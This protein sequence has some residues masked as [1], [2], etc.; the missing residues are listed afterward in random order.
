VDTIHALHMEHGWDPIA[1]MASDGTDMLM[2]VVVSMWLQIIRPTQPVKM[3]VGMQSAATLPVADG[4]TRL[5]FSVPDL[6]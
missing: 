3:S 4:R 2:A 6:T 5:T 1:P